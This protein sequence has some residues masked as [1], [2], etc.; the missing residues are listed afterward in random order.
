ME[1]YATRTGQQEERTRRF[2]PFSAAED[3]VLASIVQ[4]GG[5]GDGGGRGGGG[6]QKTGDEEKKEGKR[7]PDLKI[8]SSRP[9]R[10]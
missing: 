8:L 9:S 6:G 7:L 2:S 1:G 3:L 5:G 4:T 10:T